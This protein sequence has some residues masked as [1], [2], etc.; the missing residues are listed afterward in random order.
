MISGFETEMM[1]VNVEVRDSA[2]IL[3]NGGTV[4]FPTET[5]YGLGANALDAQAVARVFEIKQRPRFDP[6]IVH[7]SSVAQGQQ[8][9][10]MWPDTAEQLVRR[11]W[12]G[13]LTL[14]LPK[15][16]VIPHI[17]TAGLPTVALRM[18]AHPLAL[19][20][21][22]EAEVPVA[23]PSANRFGSISPTT[24]A[25]V[26]RQLGEAVD[27]VLDGGPCRVGIESTVVALAE[28]GPLLLRAGG[29]P[30]EEI[31][32]LIGPVQRPGHDPDRPTSP[33]QLA[34]HYASRTPLT[35][36]E[37]EGQGPVPPRS[38]L[39]TLRSPIYGSGFDAVE[40]L[41]ESGDL[42][43]AAANLFAALYRLDDLGL[44]RIVA[45]RVP[46][47]GAGLAIN[48]R[49]RRAAHASTHAVPEDVT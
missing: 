24:A 27:R 14:V 10:R 37:H 15:A 20:L 41:S 13:P 30:V 3:R 19:A 1:R 9:V 36:W 7:V 2:E 5:V 45:V 21:I 49:L 32:S 42:Q 47:V 39:L 48:D 22:A 17:V 6:L 35:L 11:F 38:G 34:R 46:D 33:G 4:A 25:H 16:D 31:E 12:P 44:D 26:R 28:E 18:P 43:E 40:V 8:V 29:T 23:A